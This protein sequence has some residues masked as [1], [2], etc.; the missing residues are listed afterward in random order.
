MSARSLSQLVALALIFVGTVMAGTRYQ[1]RRETQLALAES[2]WKLIYEVSFQADPD[3]G[4]Q[5]QSALLQIGRPHPMPF[6]EIKDEDMTYSGH[7]LNKEEWESSSSGNREYRLSTRHAGKYSVFA[8]FELLLRAVSNWQKRADLESLSPVREARYT[9]SENDFPTQHP[10]ISRVL[11][12]MPDESLTV[13]E[14]VEWIYQYCL[15]ELQSATQ[16]AEEGDKVIWALEQRTSPLGRAR[17]F[18]TLC[19]AIDIPARLVVGFELRQ[20]D[21]PTPHVW[22]EVHRDN[23]WIPFDPVYGFAREMPEGFVPIRRG[24]D[25]VIR[26]PG[27]GKDIK[28]V[29]AKYSIMRLPPDPAVL[30]AEAKHPAHILDLTRL[31]L[32]L[33]D[34]LSLMLLLPLG[35]LITAVFRNLVGLRTLGT[36]APALLAMS[37][38]YAAW[39][40]GLVMLMVVIIAGLVGRSLLERLHLL[41]VPRLSIVLT[42]IILCVVLA[43]SLLNYIW[44]GQTAQS[45][46]IPLV[47]LTI[48][49]ERFYVTS[50]EDSTGFA[51]QLVLGTIVVAAFCYLLLRWEY[52]GQLVLVYPE[53]HFITIAAFIIIGRYSGYR[54]TELWRFRDLVKEDNE[55][56]GPN[57]TA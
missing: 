13:S 41:M 12:G 38:I 28:D 55:Q 52:I 1:A 26:S 18:V 25:S 46:L 32:N 6:M 11:Q 29:S 33:H 50:E 27:E 10:S 51:V 15:K 5:E 22:A 23:R 30:Q 9:R 16:P 54:L 3:V 42:I 56:T 49:I 34:T 48:L 14:K 44:P 31:P 47:I 4:E 20:S 43:V 19:R 39:G 24:G 53:I 2:K 40:T 35:A 45:V 7:S 21:Q 57:P 8:E 37:F 36:F 17:V